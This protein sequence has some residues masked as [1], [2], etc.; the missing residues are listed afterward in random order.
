MNRST[1]II[2]KEIIYVLHELRG[3]KGWERDKKRRVEL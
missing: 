1:E 3:R 2:T